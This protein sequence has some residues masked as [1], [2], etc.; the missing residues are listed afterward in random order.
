MA[1]LNQIKSK[2]LELE[3]GVFQ[4]L[5]DDWLHRKGYENINPIGMMQTTDRVVKGTP[6]T[7]LIQKDGKYIFSEYTVQQD[8][9]FD[10][11][12]DDIDKCLDEGK[13]GIKIDQISEI[14]ICYLGKLATSEIN[15]LSQKCIKLNIVPTL[16]GLDSIAFG[17]K[18]CY[19]ILSEEY[20]G[21]SL[22]TGQILSTDDFVARYGNNHLT[23]PIDNKLLFQEELL[24]HGCALL[25]KSKFL[26]VTGSAGVGK[27]LFSVNLLNEMCKKDPSLKAYCVFDKGADLVRDLQSRFSEPGNYLILIDDANRLDSRIDYLLHYLNEYDASRNYRM[28]AT[29][30][31]YAVDSVV[32]KANKVTPINEL[33]VN[34]LSNDQIK[35][36]LEELFDIKNFEYQQRIQDIADGNA[37]LAIMAA[38]VAVEKQSIQSIQNVATLYDDYFGNNDGVKEIIGNP[39]LLLTA[40]AISLF[41]KI[42]KLNEDQ[43]S[44]VRDLFDIQGS[45]FWDY[46]KHLHKLEIVDLYEDE[47][48]RMSDQ[49]LSTY[50]FYS[51]VF[52]KKTISFSTIV[53][54]IFPR[55]KG[56]IADALN[57]VIR[58]FDQ[59]AIIADIRQEV[60]TIYEEL[61]SSSN[62]DEILVFLDAF[63]FALPTNA[64]TF[65]NEIIE[66]TPKHSDG[67]EKVTFEESKSSTEDLILSILCKLRYIGESELNISTNLICDYLEKSPDLLGQVIKLFAGDYAFKPDDWKYA[68][69]IQSTLV[70]LLIERMRTKDGYLYSRLFVLV[71]KSFLPVEHR[72][73][74]WRGDVI[75]IIT[76]RLSPD[77]YL[78]PIRKKL[79][80]HLS[81][82]MFDES[83]S[84]YAFEVIKEY[85]CRLGYESEDMAKADLPAIEEYLIAKF[86]KNKISHCFLVKDL[87]ERLDSISVDYPESWKTDFN[88]EILRLSD[89]LLEDRAERKMLEMGDEEYKKYRFDEIAAYFEDTNEDKFRA[90]LDQAAILHD[91]LTGRDRSY[92][93]GEG[94]RIV[95]NVVAEKHKDKFFAF[96]SIYLEYDDI[97]ELNT[98]IFIPE[99]MKNNPSKDVF[100][101]INSKE[102]RWKRHWLLACYSALPD[103]DI[104]EESL[105]Y[106]LT[107]ITSLDSWEYLFRIDFLE[108][109]ITVDESV[110]CKVTR[111]M[112]D[113]YESTKEIGFVRPLDHIFNPYSST[114]KRLMELYGTDKEIVVEAYLVMIDFDNHFDYA[115]KT[116]EILY[117]EN[118]KMLELVVDKIYGRERWPSSYTNMP[119][120]KFLWRMETYLS[121]VEAYALCVFEKEKES[122]VGH[123]NIFVK[124][125]E[126]SK[127]AREDDHTDRQE[128]FLIH[129]MK[130]HCENF[131]YIQ[132][133]FCVA[134]GMRK[135]F[136][137]DMV[138]EFIALDDDLDHFIKLDYEFTTR[139]WSGS[140]VPIFEKE[141]EF[142]IKLA[143]IF[144]SVKLINHKAYV[145]KQIDYKIGH[146]ESEKKRD[147]LESR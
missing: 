34:K 43:M 55:F 75:N 82:L 51:A 115:G 25:E 66:N 77:E 19:P 93:I 44:I 35:N 145:E 124:L 134:N 48:V 20:L 119:D 89:L 12:S 49:V 46:V 113:K 130:K 54:Y 138:R 129:S 81:L 65:T 32:E 64:L 39:N 17:I 47:V 53:K 21:L 102:F 108:K 73:H 143:S 11:I 23:T 78:D 2:L 71:A 59:R 79:I 6:D 142:L 50:L 67:W 97:F 63:W 15:Q 87:C 106:L 1:T 95:F 139:S 31:D 131:E 58:A 117:T 56:A 140:R 91:S 33:V 112:L 61:L 99:L 116:L 3:G 118:S 40:C 86:D 132:F 69:S 9:L 4:R 36:L 133:L 72:E 121:D 88:N 29:V 104:N 120:M 144:T 137:I 105:K 128:A 98:Y 68:Y 103:E 27:T 147:F 22:D 13:T 114:N 85:I 18:N 5:C 38:R 83:V 110:F 123:D 70:D 107:L 7:L 126:K 92:S 16:C 57:P 127:D 94:M 10:K 30:R 90:F 80:L 37:R 84:S 60:T 125:F 62:R 135:D 101:L 14:I 26:L 96:T 8:R 111:I 24:D 100:S 146:I 109:Y 42:D 52:H 122:Y 76:F 28:V 136:R 141:K 41:R 45:D 74:I